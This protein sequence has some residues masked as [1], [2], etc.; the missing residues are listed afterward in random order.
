[1]N[2]RN[3]RHSRTEMF[4]EVSTKFRTRSLYKQTIEMISSFH[5][6]LRTLLVHLIRARRRTT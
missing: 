5:H 2:E 6:V 1:M 4:P 3:S